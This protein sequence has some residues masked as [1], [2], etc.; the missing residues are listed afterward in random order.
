MTAMGKIKRTVDGA[1]LLGLML[2]LAYPA[3]QEAG[4]EWIGVAET[5]LMLVH[6]CLN[7]GWYKVLC[8][9]KYSPVRIF[10]TAVNGLLLLAFI[11]TAFTG[12]SMSAHAVPFLYGMG[13][14]SDPQTLHLSL[15][16]WT[17]V[18]MGVHLGI[19]LPGILGGNILQKTIAP[20][21]AVALAMLPCFGLYRFVE[22]NMLNY[23]LF[24]AHFA[25]IDFNKPAALLFIE[26]ILMFLPWIFV[27][28]E[29]ALVLGKKK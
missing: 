13:N 22:N 6:Q 21:K 26:N 7:R 27:G 4:H 14:L 2:L 25:L 15:S 16:H 19:H 28:M 29:G 17:Y 20:G 11:G 24:Q 5:V 9:G 3:T 23:L 12:M 8:K 18:L 1:M 10:S